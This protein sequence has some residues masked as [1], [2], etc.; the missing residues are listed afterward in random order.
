MFTYLDLS[1]STTLFGNL[2]RYSTQLRSLK[3]VRTSRVEETLKRY[4]VTSRSVSPENENQSSLKSLNVGSL[5]FFSGAVLFLDLTTYDLFSPYSTHWLTS[6]DQGIHFWTQSHIPTTLQTFFFQRLVSNV[7]LVL[8]LLGWLILDIK[9][10]GLSNVFTSRNVKL[11]SVVVL[12]LGLSESIKHLF[13]RQRPRLDLDL[14]SYPSGHTTI[15]VLLTG[16]FLF[17]KVLPE[18]DQKTT[19]QQNSLIDEYTLFLLWLLSGLVTALGR[20][21]ADA[22]W[23]SD[24]LGGA[25]LGASVVSM[26][27]YAKRKTS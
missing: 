13:H 1:R 9:N 21:C 25:S 5:W 7:G 11:G 8:P 27:V 4:I 12:T 24:I 20:I 17:F 10:G 2:P 18:I 26:L 19:K 23:F 16:M 6:I 22:H 14:L 3:S 15:A